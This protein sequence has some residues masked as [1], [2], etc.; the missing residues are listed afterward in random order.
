MTG[1]IT[2][3]R[4]FAADQR[5]TTL[6]EL[7]F[8][9][10]LFLLLFFAMI[11]F[12]RLSFHWVSA[13]KASAI[14]ARI[15]AVRVPACPGVPEVYDRGTYTS[16]RFGSNCRD[17]PGICTVPLEVVCA[18]NPENPTAAEIWT[19]IEPL[20]PNDATIENLRFRYSPDADTSDTVTDQIGFLGGPYVPIVTVELTGLAFRFAT[21]LSGLADLATGVT[22]STISNEI[23]MPTMSVS[24]PGEDLALGT[25]G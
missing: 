15:A 24:I 11:D 16:G 8:I 25:N 4:R 14:A 17:T 18:G 19:R 13:E 3:L 22:G 2:S 1:R 5:G 21:P 23:P 12:G 9:L 7:A 6:V 20:L 10:P